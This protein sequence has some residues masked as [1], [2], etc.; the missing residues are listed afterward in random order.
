MQLWVLWTRAA[1]M[2][3]G[4]KTNAECYFHV[5]PFFH[6]SEHPV[7]ISFGEQKQVPMEVFLKSEV[8]ESELLRS[9]GY[10]H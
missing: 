7:Q 9:G 2:M 5:S 4:C 3:T 6:K 10:L 8:A 1:P